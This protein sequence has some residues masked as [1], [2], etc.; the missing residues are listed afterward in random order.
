MGKIG[1]NPFK[2]RSQHEGYILVEKD[3]YKFQSLQ[4]TIPTASDLSGSRRHDPNVSI[5][6]RYDPN[7]NTGW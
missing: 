4:G 1:F 5:P 2:V 7:G 3:S 6:S